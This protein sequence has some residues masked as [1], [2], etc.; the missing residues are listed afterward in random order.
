MADRKRE[1]FDKIWHDKDRPEWFKATADESLYRS[2]FDTGWNCALESTRRAPIRR[3][4]ADE[5][6]L[7][8]ASSEWT[9]KIPR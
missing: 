6:W 2:W 3:N 4:G 1:S 7:T 8:G 5:K 9:N